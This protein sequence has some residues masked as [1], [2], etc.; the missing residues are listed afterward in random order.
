M[1]SQFHNF[2]SHHEHRETV[3]CFGDGSAVEGCELE[4][5][6]GV[7]VIKARFLQAH[8]ANVFGSNERLDLVDSPRGEASTLL[9]LSQAAL[10]QAEIL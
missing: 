1:G 3:G 10:S 5:F 7:D 2:V 9:L 8:W 4:D 6:R